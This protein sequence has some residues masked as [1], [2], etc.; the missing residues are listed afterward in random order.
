MIIY[1]VTNKIN[2]KQYVGMTVLTLEQRRKEHY[3]K[4]KL[5]ERKQALYNAFNKYGIENFQWEELCSTWNRDYLI[6]LE[7][8][9]IKE[10]GTQ[11]KGYNMTVGG[12][13]VISS[14]YQ[15]SYK[16]QFPDGSLQIVKG[17]KQFCRR[18]QLYG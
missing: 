9:F 14:K 13:G 1:L 4:S 8:M 5:S 2:G 7:I 12:D 6:E 10:Y 11:N 17:Y 18:N 15:D 16:L 3:K